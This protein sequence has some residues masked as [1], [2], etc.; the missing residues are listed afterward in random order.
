MDDVSELVSELNDIIVRQNSIID[1]LFI[2]LLEHIEI[3]DCDR[4]LRELEDIAKKGE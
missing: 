4:E 2:L 3:E 1:R